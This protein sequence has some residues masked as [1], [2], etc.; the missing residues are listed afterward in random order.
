MVRRILCTSFNRMTAS[1]RAVTAPAHH[2]QRTG[3]GFTIVELLIVIVVIAILAAIVIIAYN[4]ISNRAKESALKSD[5]QGGATQLE[6]TKVADGAYP[7]DATGLKKS[8]G[9]TFTYSSVG[10]TY[11]LAATS[12]SLTGKSFYVTDTGTI[13]E[14]TCQLPVIQTVTTAGCPPNRTLVRDARDD[15]TYWVQ[16]LTDG[17]CWM[18]TNLAY[19]GSGTSTYGD[20]KTLTNGTGGSTSYTVA[21]YYVPPSAN[22]TTAPT[23]PSPST[24]GGATNP[25]Y[26]YLY[27][28]CG[29]MG[30]Q[31]TAACANATTPAPNPNLSICPAGWRLPTSSEFGSLNAAINGGSTS[32]DSG[33]IASPWLAQRSGDWGN[34]FYDQ[35]SFG[36]YLSSSPYSATQ[37]LYLG[38][39]SG[40]LDWNYLS[41]KTTGF[42]VRCIAS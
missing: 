31:A 29:A 28:W 36:G 42:A 37:I 26:G 8:E 17:R 21:S 1:Y 5:L 35:G 14:G 40:Y 4:G 27:N 3:A 20:T 22:P 19:A 11:C 12:S 30:G 18:L 6:L 34:G 16:K 39:D 23:A 38:F 7:G 13:Q 32:S 41:D 25:Q 9:T 24:D 10:D 2:R 15:H 33:L